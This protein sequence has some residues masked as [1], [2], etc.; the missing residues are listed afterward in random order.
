MKD[1]RTPLVVFLH[2]PS[3]R[4]SDVDDVVDR[5]PERFPVRAPCLGYG[6]D[7]EV[8]LNDLTDR[9]EVAVDGESRDLVLV[10][11]SIG[12]CVA[13]A[14]ARRHPGRVRG[15]LLSGCPDIDPAGVDGFGSVRVPTLL[16][17]GTEDRV[18]PPQVW[19]RLLNRLPVA[20]LFFILGAGNAPMVE[21]P[22][23]FAFHLS[24]FLNDLSPV[25]LPPRRLADEAA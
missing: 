5:I 7:G 23:V 20:R 24:S 10:G 9:F 1:P 14:F 15:L 6:A 25:S 4:P 18:T 2:G 12:G 22:S 17:W 13:I 8:Q 21:R 11:S 19:H 16:L 3:G